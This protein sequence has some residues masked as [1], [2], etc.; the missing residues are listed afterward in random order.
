MTVLCFWISEFED[1]AK[2]SR[3][4]NFFVGLAHL[5]IVIGSNPS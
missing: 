1:A 5:F 2:G 3:R 4:L